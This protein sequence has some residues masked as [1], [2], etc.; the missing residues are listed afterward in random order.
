MEMEEKEA[1]IKGTSSLQHTKI[2]DTYSGVES[3]V[4][5]SH[6]PCER[7]TEQRAA[8]LFDIPEQH[9]VPTLATTPC[10]KKGNTKLMAVTLSFLNR[11]SQF[12]Y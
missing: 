8:Q 7:R 11:F 10:P 5:S 6:M 1:G 9:V 12:F 4:T 2:L 3:C